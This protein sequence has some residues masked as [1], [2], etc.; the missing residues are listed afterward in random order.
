MQKG[1]GESISRE[2]RIFV[3][4]KEISSLKNEK[5]IETRKKLRRQKYGEPGL[6]KWVEKDVLRR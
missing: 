4:T 2:T 3:D 1:G 5:L 6:R